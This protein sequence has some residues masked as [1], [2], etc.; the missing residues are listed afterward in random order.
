LSVLVLTE[1]QVIPSGQL[2]PLSVSF[3]SEECMTPML[4]LSSFFW[5]KL[6]MEAIQQKKTTSADFFTFILSPCREQLRFSGGTGTSDIV[7]RFPGVAGCHTA[8]RL[9][10]ADL[11]FLREKTGV[12][13]Q[14]QESVK[15]TLAADYADQIRGNRPQATGHSKPEPTLGANPPRRTGFHAKDANFK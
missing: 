11:E 1:E 6:K 15:T 3:W 14:D 2:I 10:R 5:L 4:K 13:S 7:R 12:R 8:P 9:E